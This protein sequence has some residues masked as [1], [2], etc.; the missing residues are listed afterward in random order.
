MNQFA[1]QNNKTESGSNTTDERFSRRGVLKAGIAAGAGVAALAFGQGQSPAQRR[2]RKTT[3]ADY[4]M[5]IDRR[6]TALVV[7][8]PQNDV[9][10]EKGVSW[11][12]LGDS[13]KENNRSEEHMS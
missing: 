12:L 9:L 11:E 5:L 10:R 4:T 7:I 1:D 2:P 6:D 13:L 3:L 8:D